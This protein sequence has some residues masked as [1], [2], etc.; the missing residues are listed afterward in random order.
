MGDD[1][2]DLVRVTQRVPADDRGQLAREQLDAVGLAE[3]LGEDLALR[4]EA[5]RALFDDLPAASDAQ[6]STA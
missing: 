6:L 2:V 4:G 3:L 5:Q 1:V